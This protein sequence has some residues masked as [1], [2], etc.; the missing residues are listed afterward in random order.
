MRTSLTNLLGT[1]WMAVWNSVDLPLTTFYTLDIFVKRY[2][3]TTHEVDRWSW[4]MQ[5][6]VETFLS[7]N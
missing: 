1:I 4:I 7:W 5:H 3:C 6:V 2:M